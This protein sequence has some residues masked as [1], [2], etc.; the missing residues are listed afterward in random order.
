[1][2][3]VEQVCLKLLLLS[4]LVLD[5]LLL[6]YQTLS[7]FFQIVDGFFNLLSLVIQAYVLL[8]LLDPVSFIER[9]AMK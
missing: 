8:N 6:L 9:A 5:G 3:Q 2:V 7:F 1:M 4:A